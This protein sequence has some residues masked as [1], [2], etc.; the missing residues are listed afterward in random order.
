MVPESHDAGYHEGDVEVEE[1]LVEGVAN[2]GHCLDVDDDEGDDSYKT[3]NEDGAVRKSSGDLRPAT[4]VVGA[5]EPSNG[6]SDGLGGAYTSKPSVNKVEGIKGE[7]KQVNKGVVSASHDNQR[8]HVD[9][10]ESP[11]PVS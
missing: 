7:A 3:S 2:D 10:R 4:L 5:E 9:D 8:D 11:C 1:E 6:V